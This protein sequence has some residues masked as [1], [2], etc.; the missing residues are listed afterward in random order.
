MRIGF[1]SKTI[2]NSGKNS[3]TGTTYSKSLDARPT[4]RP[5]EKRITTRRGEVGKKRV[6]CVAGWKIMLRGLFVE[7]VYIIPYSIHM[8]AAKLFAIEN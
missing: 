2:T 5:K 8:Y 6:E 1:S 3:H 4:E 7:K